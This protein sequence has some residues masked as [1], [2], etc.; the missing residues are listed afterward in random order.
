VRNFRVIGEVLGEYLGDGSSIL[1]GIKCVVVNSTRFGAWFSLETLSWH[2]ERLGRVGLS[3]LEVSTLDSFNGA[4]R[5]PQEL[6]P[7]AI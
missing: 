7:G 2:W 4:S 1:G 3:L 5:G 6:D